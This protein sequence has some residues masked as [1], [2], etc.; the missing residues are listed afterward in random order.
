MLIGYARVSIAD[1]TL[2]LLL[3]ALKAAGVQGSQIYTDVAS[4]AQTERRQ[5]RAV[6]STPFTEE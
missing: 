5:P 1:Q 3:Q 6:T 2:E 4:G